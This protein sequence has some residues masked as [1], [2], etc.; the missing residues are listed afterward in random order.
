MANSTNTIT[1]VFG[2][3]NLD[4]TLS[5][6]TQ[7]SVKK[8]DDVDKNDFITLL[9]TQL[10]NQDPENPMDNNRFAV[11][12]ATF[13]QLQ[14]LV[15]IREKITAEGQTDN[16][17]LASYLGTEVTI[18]SQSAEV[19]SGDGGLVK[20]TLPYE[21]DS[22]SVKLM[23]ADGQVVDAVDVGA[24]G[25]GSHTVE[26]K[27]L[28]VLDGSYDVSV[29]AK[30]AGGVSFTAIPQIAGL[31]SGF[32]PGADPTLLLGSREVKPSEITSVNMVSSK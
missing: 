5:T 24:L 19:K 12:L 20:F 11:D 23:G 31:V 30:G 6:T 16:T 21:A 29:E 9:V 2:A 18:D 8:N 26:L 3:P 10:K 17:S 4:P 1:G 27:D 25:K 28:K 15:T 14:E 32:I 22:V 7:Q 13:S